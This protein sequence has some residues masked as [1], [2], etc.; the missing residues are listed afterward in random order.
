MSSFVTLDSE[1]IAHFALLVY[2]DNQHSAWNFSRGNFNKQGEDCQCAHFDWR[3]KPALSSG[4]YDPNMK[5]G[6]SHSKHFL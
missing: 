2:I 3:K 5:E 6:E 4:V 1:C